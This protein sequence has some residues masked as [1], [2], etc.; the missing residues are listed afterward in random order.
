LP[1]RGAVR[2]NLRFGGIGSFRPIPVVRRIRVAWLYHGPAFVDILGPPFVSPE[3]RCE[4]DLLL[5]FPLCGRHN[6]L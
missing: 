1:R 3:R 2:S 5:R 4:L 6:V